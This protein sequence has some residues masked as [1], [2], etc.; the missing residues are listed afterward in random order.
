MTNQ[1]T[2]TRPGWYTSG[3]CGLAVVGASALLAPSVAVATPALPAGCVPGSGTAVTCTFTFTGDAQSFTVPEGITSLGVTAT[4][5]RGGN[6][7]SVLGGLGAVASR[8]LTV[9]PG[10]ALYVLVGG[11][12]G[13]GTGAAG[14]N[15][16]GAGGSGAGGGGGAS[17][18]RTATGGLADRQIVASGGG[19]AGG[20]YIGG[21]G[22]LVPNAPAGQAGGGG[23]AGGGGQAD[24]GGAG[25]NGGD[26]PDGSP[27][28][29][30]VG[31]AGSGTGG[32]GGGGWFGGGGGAENFGGGGGGG[33]SSYAP[34]GTISAAGV[35]AVPSVVITYGAGSGTGSLGSLFG[36]S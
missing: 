10:D 27:G 1:H 13:D 9:A 3:V 29:G 32:G 26:N 18:V 4:G 23:G 28:F 8:S 16:G 22:N 24:A 5:A 31:G 12:G 30:G 34:D 20:I 33:G 7:G 17:D 2:T 11:S 6:V 25:G 21:G 36:S 15:G 14:F 35:D 19:G